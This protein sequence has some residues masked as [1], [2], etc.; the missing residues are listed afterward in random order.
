VAEPF[1]AK[2][3][4]AARRQ[5]RAR[6]GQGLGGEARTSR[7]EAPAR[8]FDA[9][10]DLLAAFKAGALVG[11]FVAVIRAQGPRA[12][13]MPE[14]H[15]LTPTLGVLQDRGQRVA[16]LTDGRM[17]GASGK[18]LAAIHVTPGSDLRWRTREAARWRPSS[19]S[20]PRPAR[21]DVLLDATT[22]A[23]RE[24]AAFDLAA[25]RQSASA[26]NC[27][28]AARTGRL[29]RARRLHLVRGRL[30]DGDAA[31]AGDDRRHRRHQR[32]LRADRSSPQPQPQ[33][34]QQQSLRNA[35][36][37]SLQ[38]AAEHYLAG[39]GV[40]P[41]RR[42]RGRLP[43]RRRR[44]PPDQSRLVVQPQRTAAQLGARLAAT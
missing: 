9:Q 22:V 35:E 5:P 36:F 7:I 11:D 32:A 43:G 44:N 29:G 1:D 13:G 17:S 8:V 40:Q 41:R 16:L 2:A 42:H 15:K 39:V 19:A 34:L 12:N 21:M 4:C 3:A 18:V 23:A 30:S 20:T 14:L 25:N 33:L 6:R 10:D 26:A 27:S 38:H 28:A 31:R 24:P 37:A